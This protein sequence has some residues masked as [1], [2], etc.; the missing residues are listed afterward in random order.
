MNKVTPAGQWVCTALCIS[1]G[2]GYIWKP[3]WAGLVSR[4][5][6]I[7]LVVFC[8]MLVCICG[9]LFDRARVYLVCWPLWTV[10]KMPAAQRLVPVSC[11]ADICD[12]LLGR[13]MT[14][15][16]RHKEGTRGDRADWFRLLVS[17]CRLM[18]PKTG[19]ELHFKLPLN[20]ISA[21]GEIFRTEAPSMIFQA[22]FHTMT[23]VQRDVSGWEKPSCRP[24]LNMH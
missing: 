3:R 21:W 19:V 6:W 24:L 15:Q 9:V 22:Q 16:S 13:K 18:I 17:V 14:K 10:A 11:T 4:S 1:V 23:Q 7:Y 2:A 12:I 20:Q 8:K 5:G